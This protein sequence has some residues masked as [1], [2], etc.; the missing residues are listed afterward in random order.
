LFR[1]ILL[2]RLSGKRTTSQMNN[3]DWIVT[4]AMG[5]MIASPILIEKVTLADASLGIAMLLLLQFAVTRVST[6]SDAFERLVKAS[7]TLLAYNGSLL[8]GAM[9]R[10][11]V[12]RAEVMAALREGGLTRVDQV[13]AV[14]LETDASMSVLPRNERLSVESIDEVGRESPAKKPGA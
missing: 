5:S 13:G 3:F 9:R 7:P 2:I 12:T 11:R 1:S 14:V 4:V 6:R 8:H 10:E